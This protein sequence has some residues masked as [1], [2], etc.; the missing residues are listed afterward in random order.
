M[1]RRDLP[2]GLP[3]TFR[4]IDAM[5]RGAT[6]GQLRNPELH[7][8]HHGSRARDEPTCVEEAAAQLLATLTQHPVALCGT[9]AAQIHRMPGVADWVPDDV[10]HVMTRTVSGRVRRTRVEGRR[11]LERRAT[12]LVNGLPVTDAVDTWRDLATELPLDDLIIAGDWLLGPRS[13]RSIDELL[14]AL[15]PG[16]RGAARAVAALK[17]IRA[18]SASPAETRTRVVL[19]RAGLPE[20]ELN[21]NLVSESGWVANVDMYWRRWNY[22]LDYD[23][24]HH[25]ER[26]EQLDRDLDRERL[27]RASGFGYDRVSNKHLRGDRPEVIGIASRGLRAAGWRP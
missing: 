14:A 22:A 25:R 6:R 2:E 8:P 1:R 13:T 9:T 19:V 5:A 24:R 4:V 18:G 17:E 21:V 7:N 26:G 10:L 16:D 20:P 11:G 27:I 15:R 12:T 23:G 3:A